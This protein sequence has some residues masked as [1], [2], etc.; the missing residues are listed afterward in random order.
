MAIPQA[1]DCTAQSFLKPT[2]SGKQR[3]KLWPTIMQVRLFRFIRQVQ[4]REWRCS[5]EACSKFQL[6]ARGETKP[7]LGAGSSRKTKPNR[8]HSK[9]GLPRPL[10]PIAF[11]AFWAST[12]CA[13]L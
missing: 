10:E 1:L 8:E 4:C 12:S 13:T 5:R 7:A 3:N 6:C 2:I 9:Q 11:A